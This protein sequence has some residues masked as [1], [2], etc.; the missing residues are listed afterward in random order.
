MR[1]FV[2]AL[3]ILTVAAACSTDEPS[4]ETTVA[5][6]A[7]TT[8]V[9]ASD[10]AAGLS[11]GDSSLGEIL[12]DA[13]GRTL[14]LFVPDA[15]GDSTCYDECEANWPPLVGEVQGGDGIDSALIGT[16]PRTDG[17]VQATYDGWPLYHFAGDA[18]SGDTNGQGLNE[19]WYVVSPDGAPIGMDASTQDDAGSSI[20]Y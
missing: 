10:S 11:V 16:A 8:T 18:A 17:S 20:D 5:P 1:R 3:A 4:E 15:Q 6:Q 13:D 19:I 7:T 12:V 2:I 9:G 14:Y